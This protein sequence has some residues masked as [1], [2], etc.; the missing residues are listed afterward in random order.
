MRVRVRYGTR[1]GQCGVIIGPV[2]EGSDLLIEFA[3][4][5]RVPYPV[6]E[7]TVLA[8]ETKSRE[9][10]VVAYVEELTGGLSAEAEA[11]LRALLKGTS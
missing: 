1:I 3:D 7:V 8:V 4:G 11:K 10:S 2:D 6:H 9:E 5:T